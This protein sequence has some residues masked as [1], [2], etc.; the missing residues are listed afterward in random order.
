MHF[1]NES[2]G[3]T[4]RFI[5]GHKTI[6]LFYN[7]NDDKIHLA[8]YIPFEI[9]PEIYLCGKVGNFT[10]IRKIDNKLCEA[11]KEK[12]INDIISINYFNLKYMNNDFWRKEDNREIWK[13]LTKENLKIIIFELFKIPLELKG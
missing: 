10:S 8:E 3:N 6:G 4:A 13:K 7:S 12:L 9:N 2:D 11:C 5:D 1:I